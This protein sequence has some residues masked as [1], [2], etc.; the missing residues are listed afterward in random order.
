M[1]E[2]AKPVLD[3]QGGKRRNRLS[4]AQKQ[5][6]RFVLWMLGFIVA[7]FGVALLASLLR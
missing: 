1:P 5:A 4:A 6:I 7:G 2:P 3:Y